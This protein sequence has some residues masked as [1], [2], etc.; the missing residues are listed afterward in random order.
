VLAQT[1][2]E[3]IYLNNITDETRLKLVGEFE[4]VVE[5]HLPQRAA[6]SRVAP[7][8]PHVVRVVKLLRS[9]LGRKF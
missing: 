1:V 6:R 3:Y 8:Q 5:D 4:V 9:A 7:H 2:R